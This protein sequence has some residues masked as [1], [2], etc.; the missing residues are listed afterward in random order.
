MAPHNCCNT[1]NSSLLCTV[2]IFAVHFYS[3][4]H[5]CNVRD[6]ESEQQLSELATMV[7][8]RWSSNTAA[9]VAGCQH[10]LAHT[11]M[12]GPLRCIMPTYLSG[13]CKWP[14]MS[15][16]IPHACLIY[17]VVAYR[18][19][20]TAARC[21]DAQTKCFDSLIPRVGQARCKRCQRG[22]GWVGLCLPKNA[23]RFLTVCSLLRNV[24]LMQL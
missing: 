17:S 19:I 21:L 12:E 8:P 11:C 16:P 23:L 22:I 3:L 5:G 7:R 4:K 6:G 10:C 24:R 15:L 9:A 2:G 18:V 13:H 20:H 14:T 1:C